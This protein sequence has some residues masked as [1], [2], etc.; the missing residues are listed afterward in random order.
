EKDSWVRAQGHMGRSGE[1]FGTVQVVSRC[2]GV[3]VGKG[4]FLAGKLV[5]GTVWLVVVSKFGKTGPPE[6]VPELRIFDKLGFNV[7]LFD[8]NLLPDPAFLCGF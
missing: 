1:S 4:V 6:L 5:R 7:R 8:E 3:A 2:K